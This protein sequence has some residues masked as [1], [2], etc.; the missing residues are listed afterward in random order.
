MVKLAGSY[1]IGCRL[2]CM[3]TLAF[4]MEKLVLMCFVTAMLLMESRSCFVAAELSASFSSMSVSRGLYFGF[5]VCLD[6]L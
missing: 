1:G 3:P 5:V 2:F 4:D 6:M